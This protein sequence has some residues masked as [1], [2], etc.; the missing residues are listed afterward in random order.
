MSLYLMKACVVDG[1]SSR[2][3]QRAQREQREA[4]ECG[5]RLGGPVTLEV[6]GWLSCSNHIHATRATVQPA[7]TRPRWALSPSVCS[8]IILPLCTA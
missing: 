2:R 3:R 4:R 8:T 6:N 1:N 5:R 7:N